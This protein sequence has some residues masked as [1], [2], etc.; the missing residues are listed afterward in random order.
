MSELQFKQFKGYVGELTAVYKR[1]SQKAVKVISSKDVDAFIRPYFDQIMDNHEE[2][3]V[4]YLSNYNE[5]LHVQE[6]SKGGMTGTVVDIRLLMREALL[7]QTVRFCL[8]HNHPSG[9]LKASQA[10][11]AMT[12]KVK[13]AAK[14]F[15][16]EVLDHVIMTRE[17]YLSFADEGLL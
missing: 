15:D 2:F 13:K 10:D 14:F 1:T 16:I 4:V 9:T 3:K 17:S 6:L 12:E 11:I 5:V 7:L 8:V